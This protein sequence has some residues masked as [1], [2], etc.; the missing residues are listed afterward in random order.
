MGERCRKSCAPG[1]YGQDCTETCVCHNN[2]T[3][4]PVSGTCICSSGWKGTTCEEGTN[5]KFINNYYNLKD[6]EDNSN[7]E[8]NEILLSLF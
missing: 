1:T 4:D 6:V 3:C 5:R 8:V 7:F 2:G